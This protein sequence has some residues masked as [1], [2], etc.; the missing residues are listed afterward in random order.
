M[1][2][3]TAS[4]GWAQLEQFF[5]ASLI[6]GFLD[7]LKRSGAPDQVRDT[8]IKTFLRNLSPDEMASL[9]SQ[10]ETSDFLDALVT[11]LGDKPT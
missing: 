1:E 8:V 9:R 4:E 11:S 7:Q 3:L 2:V 10:I 6:L 5:R